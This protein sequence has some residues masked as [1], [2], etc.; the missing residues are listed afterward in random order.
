TSDTTSA[1]SKAALADIEKKA[2]DVELQLLSKEELNSDDK[3]FTERHRLY[4]SLVWL[5]AEVGTGGG[6]VAGGAEYRPTDAQGATLVELEKDLVTAKA[7][8]T[9]FMEKD[10]KAFNASMAGKLAPL[11][12]ELPKGPPKPAI[13]P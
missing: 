11:S 2:L 3:W 7:A 6:D 4:M 1:S 12:D 9:K 10:V 13:L 8:F 5:S